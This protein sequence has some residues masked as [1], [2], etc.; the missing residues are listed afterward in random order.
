MSTPSPHVVVIGAGAFGGW[1]ALELRRRGARVTLLDAWGP[2]HSRSS[3]GG[4]TRIIRGVYGP[5]KVY[6]DWVARAFPLWREAEARFHLPLYHRTG[7]LWMCGDDDAYVRTSL[8][9]LADAGLAIAELSVAEARRRFPQIDFAG[10]AS[11]FYEEEAGYLLARRACRAVAAGVA[12]EGGEVRLAAAAPG[13]TAH[14]RLERLDLAGGATLAADLYVFACGPWLGG[15]F[16]EVIGERRILSSRQEVFYF[17]PPAGDPRFE[18]GACPVWI[19]LSGER[20]YYGIPGNEHRGFKLADD[21]RGEP[22]DPTT[23]ERT[24]TSALLA[25]ARSA[26]AR[27]FPAL[28]GAPLVETR[29][30]QYE[31]TPDGHLLFDR[32]PHAANVWLLGGGSGH[33]FKLGPAL[34]QY[35]AEAILADRAPLPL[36]A[37]ER[38]AFT[39][40]APVRTQFDAAG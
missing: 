25:A 39:H 23:A 26:M 24:V 31:N 40:G 13:P 17:G 10:V 29:I 7:C 8:P 1:T 14:G 4:E 34:G 2:G 22:L 12:A 32:H 33:G 16:P 30:C 21:T 18:E 27:R 9:H 11:V 19:D 6:V 5:D 35:A 3:S 15:L 20:I 28:A 36:F 38:P 37:L